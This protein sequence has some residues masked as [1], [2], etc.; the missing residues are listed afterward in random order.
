MPD[1]TGETVIEESSG[2]WEL[3]VVSAQFH[4]YIKLL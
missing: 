3:S 2:I 1:V 4:V